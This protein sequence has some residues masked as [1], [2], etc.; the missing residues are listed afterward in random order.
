MI[1]FEGRREKSQKNIS[2]LFQMTNAEI[3]DSFAS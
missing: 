1:D 3:W 2:N